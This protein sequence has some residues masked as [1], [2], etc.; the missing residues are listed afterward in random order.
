T[1]S[2]TSASAMARRMARVGVVTVS[3]RRSTRPSGEGMRPAPLS[4]P[5]G[6]AEPGGVD[7]ADQALL[8][9]RDRQRAVLAEDASVGET[10]APRRRGARLAVEE[11]FVGPERPVEPH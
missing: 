11:P 9:D 6:G 1:S 8:H 2:P 7:R 3:E 4:A 10:A 5:I